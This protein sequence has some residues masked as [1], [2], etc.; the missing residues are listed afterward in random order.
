MLIYR[1]IY[2][3]PD[4]LALGTHIKDPFENYCNKIVKPRGEI[5]QNLN[6]M[7]LEGIYQLG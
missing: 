2:K 4:W 5:D 6:I 7:Q 1:N 3:A